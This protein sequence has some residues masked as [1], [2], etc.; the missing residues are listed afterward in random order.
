MYHN[1]DDDE[2][3]GGR[4]RSMSLPDYALQPPTFF[5]GDGSSHTSDSEEE[6]PAFGFRPTGFALETIPEGGEAPPLHSPSRLKY[7]HSSSPKAKSPRPSITQQQNSQMQYQPQQ[8]QYIAQ[9]TVPHLTLNLQGLYSEFQ[10][11]AIRFD[12]MYQ[13]PLA[14]PLLFFSFP[15]RRRIGPFS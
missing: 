12:V 8:Q 7:E 4:R 13:V 3:K 1:W 11:D 10:E 6:V 5:E 15:N 9:Q 14:E 2:M